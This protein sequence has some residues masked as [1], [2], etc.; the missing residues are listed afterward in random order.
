MDNNGQKGDVFERYA[1]E[2]IPQD[3]RQPW[4]SIAL[5]WIGV[6]IC[7][8]CLMLGG[9]LITGLSL[10][11]AF[12]AGVIGYT[13]VVAFMSFQGMQ[14]ADLG[15][16]TVVNASSAFGESGAR[17]LT[18]LVLAIGC[19]GWF[20]VQANVCGAAFSG[21][22]NE[23]VG[24]NIPVWVSSLVWGVIMLATAII[25]FNALKYL[26][27]IAVPALVLLAIYGTY[28]AIAKFG[29]QTLA[30]YQPPSPFPFVQGIALAVGTFAVGGVIA[31]D[32][33][34]YA[35]GRKDAVLSSVVGVWPAGVALLL[36][37]SVMA[38]VAGSYDIT[39]VLT[40]MGIPAAGLVI[41]ILATWTTNTVNAYSGGLAITSM[42]KLSDS[43]RALATGVA[44][45][46]GTILAVAG[47]IDYFINYLMLLT[48]GIPPVAGVMIADYWIVRKGIASRWSKYP[49]V[50]WGGIISWLLGV[51]AANTIKAGV[52]PVTGIIVSMLCYLVIA[53]VLRKQVSPAVE[54]KDI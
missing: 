13:I 22:M 54:G 32:Y 39:M 28:V 45:A 12:L 47:I 11:N 23:W 44:G 10:G 33:S 14:G 36:M 17:V 49:G 25:G 48:S 1:L 46:L 4:F 43:K 40:K 15:R 9:A 18:S 34:R 50:N 16:P 6:M 35:R 37:G 7:V 41:L 31:A 53:M 42:F 52:A 27:Y 2:A 3:I 8:P 5:I 26:N 30:N 20:G 19:L 24:L 38:V 29:T 21:I 51:V